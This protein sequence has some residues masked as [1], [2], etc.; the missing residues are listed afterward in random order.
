MAERLNSH[1]VAK[2]LSLSLSPT[3][4]LSPTLPLSPSVLLSLSVLLSFSLSYALSLS[5][6]YSTPLSILFSLSLSFSLPLSYF[7][8]LSYSLYIILLSPSLPPH[9]PPLSPGRQNSL[10]SRA[11]SQ[12]GCS[13]EC[14]VFQIWRFTISYF[15][16]F[17]ISGF[18]PGIFQMDTWGS[19]F[20][21]VLG[22]DCLSPCDRPGKWLSPRYW[23]AS[24]L[25]H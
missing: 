1:S 21:S 6:S 23:T 9:L 18:I 5:V 3:F 25:E 11:L 14:T 22:L 15:E 16:K 10:K 24:L 4:S 19:T 20:V 12:L 17:K 13:P 8:S 7:C 2:V